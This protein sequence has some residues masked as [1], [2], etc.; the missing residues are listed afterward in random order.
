MVN[1]KYHLSKTKKEKE[2]VNL[3]FNKLNGYKVNPKVKEKD[4]ILVNKIVFVD[5]EF[6]EKIIRKKIDMKIEYL[7]KQ[8]KLM[9]DEGTDNGTIKKSLMDAEKLRVQLIN[10]YVKYLGHTYYG[11]TLKK[12]ELIIEELNFKLYMKQFYQ[13]RVHYYNSSNEKEGRRGR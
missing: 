12:I 7:L 11:L 9:Q 1:K 8:L 3:E 6:S 10:K 13:D 2:A 4:G 5:N